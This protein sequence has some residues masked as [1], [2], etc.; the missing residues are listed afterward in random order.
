MEAWPGKTV[1][2]KENFYPKAGQTP[3]YQTPAL[4]I[5]L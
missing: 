4:L 2:T 3:N 5:L 1:I